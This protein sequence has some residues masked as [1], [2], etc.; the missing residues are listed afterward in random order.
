MLL[1]T[2]AASMF[3]SVVGPPMSEFNPEDYVKEWLKKRSSP[4]LAER[5]KGK[6]SNSENNWKIV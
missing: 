6:I 2:A 5:S 4:A 1:K 3:I